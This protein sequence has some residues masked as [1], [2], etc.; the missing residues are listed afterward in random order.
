MAGKGKNSGKQNVATFCYQCVA[1]PDLMKVEVENGIAMRL[2]SN[3]VTLRVWT[4]P[5][6]ITSW[7]PR[8]AW[9]WNRPLCPFSSAPPPSASP[10]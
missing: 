4:S 2:A 9:R 1:G 6:M 10:S 8:P 3:S 5:S 7:R